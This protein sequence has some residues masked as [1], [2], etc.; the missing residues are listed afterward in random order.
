MA[1]SCAPGM[2]FVFELV[3]LNY[4]PVYMVIYVYILYTY[5]IHLTSHRGVAFQWQIASSISKD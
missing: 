4:H 3:Q 2:F 5:I 1:I